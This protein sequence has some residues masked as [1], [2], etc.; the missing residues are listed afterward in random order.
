MAH[1]TTSFF[2][3]AAALCGAPTRAA[4]PPPAAAG[5]NSHGPPTPTADVD[6]EK[7]ANIT[8]A[9]L[10]CI[11]AVLILYRLITGIANHFRKMLC[12][13]NAS[14]AYFA[15]P[16]PWFAALKRHLIYAPLFGRR[17]HHEL[18][19]TRGWPL[20]VL[21]TR[22]QS[23]L[24]AGIIAMNI[25]LAFTGIEWNDS[26]S[27]NM[28]S[29]LRNRSGSLAVANM[30][31]LV[32]M[33]GRNNPL[34]T[35]TGLSYDTFNMFHRWFGR[36]VAFEALVHVIAHVSKSVNLSGW[37]GFGMSIGSST[38]ILTGVIVSAPASSYY[39]ESVAKDCD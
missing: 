22:F 4:G 38:I 23:L 36:I 25:T 2:V 32:I 11:A 35:L 29:H 6:N 21:P 14:Q 7:F 20:G 9:I 24:L 13:N 10:A 3:L 5:A 19:L 12:L 26:G 34:I 30:I 18:R 28:L 33:A 39:C 27:A 16:T 37:N 15:Q 31:P 8:L 17:H 1:F